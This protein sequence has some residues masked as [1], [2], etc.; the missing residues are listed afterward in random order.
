M[1][2]AH[3]L[4]LPG[5]CRDLLQEGKAFAQKER[6]DEKAREK[7]QPL[8]EQHATPGKERD[9]LQS[10]WLTSVEGESPHGGST[11]ATPWSGG[12]HTL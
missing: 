4:D 8:S 7:K 11:C 6:Q 3:L 2:E 10:C 5:S 12:L 1:D 9:R